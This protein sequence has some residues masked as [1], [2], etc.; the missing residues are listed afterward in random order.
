[1]SVIL[2][3]MG[4]RG[5]RFCVVVVICVLC[6]PDVLVGRATRHLPEE[7][8][9]VCECV[10]CVCVCLCWCTSMTSV[11]KSGGHTVVSLCGCVLV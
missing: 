4:L 10:L 11:S 9:S 6:N 3:G 2:C 8:N 5:G 1:M 7:V